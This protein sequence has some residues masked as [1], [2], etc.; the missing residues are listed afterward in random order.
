MPD[1]YTITLTST[2]EQ[3]GIDSDTYQLILVFTVDLN[4][5]NQAHTFATKSLTITDPG[6]T[7][8]SYDLDKLLV[9]PANQ[10]FI[11]SDAVGYIN[12]LLFGDSAEEA[13]TRKSFSVEVKRTGTSVFKGLAFDN[14]ITS[15]SSDNTNDSHIIKISAS[16]DTQ[17][18]AISPLFDD[19]GTRVDPFGYFGAL[20]HRTFIQELDTL[21]GQIDSGI[22]HAA[23]DI[24]LRCSWVFKGEFAGPLFHDF[25]I[26]EL[27][28]SLDIYFT[29]SYEA[30]TLADVLKMYAFQF[31]CFTGVLNSDKAFFKELFFYDSSSTQ[32]LGKIWE[33]ERNYK[34]R[35]IEWTKIVDGLGA[36]EGEDGTETSLTQKRIK[37][38]I[39]YDSMQGTE[40]GDTYTDFTVKTPTVDATFRNPVDAVSLFWYTF[41]N[42]IVNSRVDRFV[43]S[44]VDYDITKD[45]QHDSKN[46]NPVSVRINW[47]TAK[48]TIEGLLV[49]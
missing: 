46:Y 7:D 27:T 12:G 36:A 44:G 9:V 47:A 35:T 37:K 26:D 20:T 34:F 15:I 4:A 18:L 32:T 3:V 17:K 28:V 31:G 13:A 5:A 22:T 25:T 29:D 21:F 41:R 42:S 38:F 23:G 45:F 48:T 10:T 43:V 14:N 40:G 30:A 6:I 2:A 1:P 19:G 39:L 16:P 24:D 8:W 11:L 33:W 49:A